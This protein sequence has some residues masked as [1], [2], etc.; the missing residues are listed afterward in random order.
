MAMIEAIVGV[1]VGVIMFI[2]VAVPVAVSVIG[3]VN[4]TGYE[5]GETVAKIIPLGLAVGSLILVFAGVGV[6]AGQ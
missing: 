4:W 3:A 6:F 2:A 5:T 1:I